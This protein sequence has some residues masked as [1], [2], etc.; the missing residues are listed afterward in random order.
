M[1]NQH[2]DFEGGIIL[3]IN[4]P[5]GW[6]STDV[7][8]KV[9]VMMRKLGYP[10]IKIG[11]AGT[12]D[13][14]ATG[15]LLVCLGKATKRVDE[16]QA[17]SK[18]YITTICL[19][20]TTPSFDLEH[21]VDERYPFEHINKQMVAD[22]L[23]GFKGK[24]EQVPPLYS[25]KRIEGK[26]AYEYAREGKEVELRT[27]SVT[28]YHLELIDYTAPFL[29]IRIECS[30]GTYIRS[31]ARDIGVELSSGGHLTELVRSRSG[32]YRVSDAVTLEQLEKSL[33][34]TLEDENKQTHNEQEQDETIA[35]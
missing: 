29:Q 10:K 33:G 15:V 6:T 12:L 27:A 25:A 22:I 4:K 28:I 18:E 34:I 30:K 26:R 24:Q 1:I 3:N 11:H 16:L 23:T 9:K 35:V 13:P 21:D 17:Q 20:A 14:L 32:E 7:V 5:Y 8:R 19:G 31:L 2:A